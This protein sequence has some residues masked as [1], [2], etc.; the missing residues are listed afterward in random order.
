MTSQAPRIILASTSPRRRE[1][2]AHLG[3]PYDVIGSAFDEEAIPFDPGD[4]GGWTVTLALGKARAVAARAGGNALVI[5]ADTTVVLDGQV[6]NKPIDATDAA[7]ML[8]T[9]SGRTHQVY[10]G[11]VV[12][13]VEGGQVALEA[14]AYGVTDVTFKPLTDGFIADYVATGE[15]LDKAGAYGIQNHGLALIDH[16]SGDYYNVVGFPLYLVR[17]LLVPCYPDIAPAPAN[18]DLPFPVLERN[19]S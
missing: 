17:E 14:T 8:R 3:L 19:V 9:L 15:P 5:G 10:T 1:L 2:L 18:P 13:P 11:V 12:V 4:P 16:I 6:Y 7:R